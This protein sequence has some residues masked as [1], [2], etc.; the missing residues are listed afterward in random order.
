MCRL[1]SLCNIRT[2][3][4]S[5]LFFFVECTVHS[6]KTHHM[7]LSHVFHPF[8]MCFCLFY[9]IHSLIVWW[10]KEGG[11]KYRSVFLLLRLFY[12]TAKIIIT[13][14]SVIGLINSI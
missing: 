7:K 5:F 1:F 14:L 13:L 6:Q 11:V 12:V 8:P 9:G 4:F 2:V 10:S 3:F